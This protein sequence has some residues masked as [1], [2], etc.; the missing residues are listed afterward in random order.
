LLGGVVMPNTHFYVRNHFQIPELDVDTWRLGVGGLVERPLTLSL[1]DLHTMR[2]ETLVVTLECAGNGRSQLDPPVQGEKWEL[3]AVST[4][5]WTGVPLAE[6][7]DRAG[8]KPRAR[9]VLFRGA[10]G[11]KVGDAAEAIRFERSLELD[12]A[13]DGEALLA[14]AMNGEPLPI[15]HGYPLRVVMPGWYAVASVKWLTEI[16][17]TDT[18][19]SGH[20]QADTYYYEHERDG[21]V[22]REP[23]SLQ[24]V[25]ALI[26]EPTAGEAVAAGDLAI[27]GVAWSGAAPIARVEVSI[28]TGP[29]QE[30][31]LVGAR[32]RH[33]WQWWELITRLDER[34]S[35]T[36]RARATDLADRTQPDRADWNRLGYGN[37]AVQEV[38]IQVR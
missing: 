30:A 21:E 31:R 4:A 33:S 17:L 28:G 38:A 9:E 25:R 11:G 12:D 5:E 27:R 24:R 14:Y 23:V 6:V 20:F 26:T 13:R 36:V 22:V 32:N 34:G 7:L 15:Q 18:K 35:T 37:N 16:E 3:G 1:R 10:D 8:V 29:W 2:S 19:F